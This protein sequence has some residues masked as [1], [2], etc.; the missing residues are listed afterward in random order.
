MCINCILKAEQPKCHSCM[1]RGITV[2]WDALP[3]CCKGCDFIDEHGHC[4]V[5]KSLD[6]IDKER[7]GC[8]QSGR[9][10]KDWSKLREETGG[11]T[12]GLDS[13]NG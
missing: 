11:E 2:G 7:C 6:T 1:V 9:K 10:V 3:E 13:G 4:A 8:R 5:F 12:D